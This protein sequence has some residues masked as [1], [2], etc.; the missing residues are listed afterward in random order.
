MFTKLLAIAALV[1]TVI[2]STAASAT[3]VKLPPAMLGEWCHTDS[4]G[5]IE[6]YRRWL[7]PADI[8]RL[9]V[10]PARLT[11]NEA[12]CKVIAVQFGSEEDDPRKNGAYTV[13]YSCNVL[14]GIKGLKREATMTLFGKE[15]DPFGKGQLAI[16]WNCAHPTQQCSE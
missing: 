15:Q 14:H 5:G 3:Q 10:K 2:V 11:E 4:L 9:T 12:D 7:M 6:T 16:V 13:K 1:G 8:C